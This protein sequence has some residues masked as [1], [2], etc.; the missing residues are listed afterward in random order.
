MAFSS[1]LQRVIAGTV[2]NIMESG[3]DIQSCLDAADMAGLQMADMC[4]FVF[5]AVW[6]C[7]V[8]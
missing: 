6:I 4:G 7:L 3:L 1:L 2:D 8:D 5:G